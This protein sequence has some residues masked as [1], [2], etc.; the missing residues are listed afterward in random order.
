ML[1]KYRM[2]CAPADTIHSAATIPVPEPALG[3]TV[4]TVTPI[5]PEIAAA[6]IVAAQPTG[7]A[8]FREQSD[9]SVKILSSKA[10]KKMREDFSAQSE[11]R[12]KAQL[13]TTAKEL[14]YAS[15]DDMI[16]NLRSSRTAGK[17]N[18]PTPK[19]NNTRNA[20]PTAEAA[21][22]TTSNA[23]SELSRLERRRLEKLQKER[24]VDRRLR[25][26]SERKARAYQNEIE[27]VRVRA[28]LERAAMKAGVQD[29]DYAVTLLE[30][31]INGKDS[32]ALDREG[33]NE[34][35]FFAGLR[36]SHP[37]LF[38]EQVRPLTTGTGGTPTPAAPTPTS[39]AGAAATATQF[40][41]M[42]ASRAD[43]SARLK[44]LGLALTS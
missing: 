6:P 34:E 21:T 1:M 38:G 5:A 27:M 30:R 26:Q 14:G 40:D 10:Y 8:E 25:I 28:E 39:V 4:T 44:K 41:G 32:T 7:T 43:V 33:F 36:A 2:F 15:H 17:T 31:A 20:A 11:R 42:K 35:N 29:V 23:R 37:M 24:E 22:L 12:V 18:Q 19:A 3:T 13:D 16:K 9:G